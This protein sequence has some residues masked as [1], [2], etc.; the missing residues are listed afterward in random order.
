MFQAEN[1]AQAQRASRPMGETA[2]V[3]IMRLASVFALGIAIFIAARLIGLAVAGFAPMRFD[4]IPL[5]PRS[6]LLCTAL[7]AAASGLG[8]WSVARW[9]AML[10]IATA[11]SLFYMHALRIEVYGDGQFLIIALS[12]IILLHAVTYAWAVL[13]RRPLSLR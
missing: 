6:L 2:L 3:V 7:C 9:G 13:S 10:W 1:A 5:G 4:L 12:V 8:L 11:A